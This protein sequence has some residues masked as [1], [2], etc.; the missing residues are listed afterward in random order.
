MSWLI[1]F[2][3][4]PMPHLPNSVI[5]PDAGSARVCVESRFYQQR[6][7]LFFQHDANGDGSGDTPAIVWMMPRPGTGKQ[8]VAM[9]TKCK[10][11][12]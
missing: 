2:I 4:N 1:E 5:Q 3:E 9:I 11:T 10:G 12:P 8:R 6:G 7:N